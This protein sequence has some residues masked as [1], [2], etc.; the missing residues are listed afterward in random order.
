[1]PGEPYRARDARLLPQHA[2]EPLQVIGH[3]HRQDVGIPPVVLAEDDDRKIGLAHLRHRHGPSMPCR[4]EG[5][6]IDGESLVTKPSLRAGRVGVAWLLHLRRR[7]RHTAS[8][9]GA[10]SLWLMRNAREMRAYL[11][12]VGTGMARAAPAWWTPIQAAFR[13]TIKELARWSS[14]RFQGGG[15]E[16]QDDPHLSAIAFVIWWVIQQPTS[17]AHLVHN[18]GTLL[19]NAAHGLSHFVASI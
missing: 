11:L 13:S 10:F 5:C 8:R 1:M 17:A 6:Q 7:Q 4:E 3:R 19:T 14:L 16:T 9:G 12:P 15:S 18:I 2:D